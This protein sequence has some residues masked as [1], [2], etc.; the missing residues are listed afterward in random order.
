MLA[1]ARRSEEQLAAEAMPEPRAQP[2]PVVRSALW[3]AWGDALGFPTELTRDEAQLQRRLDAVSAEA[4]VP[5]SRRVGGRY[6][7]TVPLP[8]GTYSDDTQLR[9]AVSRCIRAP[10]RFD[11]EAFSKIEL[12]VFLSYGLGVGRATKSAAKSIE[13]GGVRWYSNFYGDTVRYVA[14]GGNGAAMRIQPHVWASGDFR[15]E[16]YLPS[17]VRDVL[18]THGHPR[19]LIGA[20][21]HALSLGTT[22]R[23]SAIPSPPRWRAMVGYL[24]RL[25]QVVASDEVLAEQWVPRWEREAGT[26]WREALLSTIGETSDLVETAAATEPRGNDADAYARLA[27]SLGGLDPATRGSGVVSAILSLWLA[28]WSGRNSERGPILA[29]NLLGSDTDTNASMAGALAGVIA[30]SG[31]RGSILD[32]DYIAT[33]AARLERLAEQQPSESFPHPDPLK[34]RPPKTLADVV[35]LLNGRIAV[36][37]LGPAREEGEPFAGQGRPGGMWQWLHLHFG[38]HLLVKR[39]PDLMPL[40]DY[41]LPRQRPVR[42]EQIQLPTA[43]SEPQLPATVEAAVEFLAR[44]DFDPRLAMQLLR[45]FANEEHGVTKA[46][47]F[48]A[49]VA[50]ALQQKN[51][52]R[53]RSRASTQRTRRN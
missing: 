31:P 37:G 18:V 23:E 50:Q 25:D 46:G 12:P 19:G 24:E 43:A 15:P 45:Q 2:S 6:G 47:L 10:Q 42:P 16:T 26:G 51:D 53:R 38:Q 44:R 22:L 52:D 49:L 3:A 34:W 1:V 29:A 41:A 14:A 28:Y 4:T 9:L 13:R 8:A 36:A 27:A 21:L 30:P 33:E 48:G 11:V 32:R 39:R 7:P 40:P 17:V 35:G 5:W 20:A